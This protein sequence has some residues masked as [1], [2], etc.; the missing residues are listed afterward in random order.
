VPASPGEDEEVAGSGSEPALIFGAVA[1]VVVV[2][3]GGMVIAR[4]RTAVP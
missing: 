1:M 2:V 3:I 4:R